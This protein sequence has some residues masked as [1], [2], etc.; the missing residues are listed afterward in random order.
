MGRATWLDVPGN[1]PTLRRG[2][3]AELDEHLVDIAP[4]P[5]FG[6]VVAFYDRMRRYRKM[7]A[8][9]PMR[10]IVAATDV[11]AGSAET[12]MHP[13]RAVG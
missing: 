9:M 3:V 2:V 1:R 12:Q 8:S 11:T 13:G 4:P 10:R 7:G 5:T 6:R